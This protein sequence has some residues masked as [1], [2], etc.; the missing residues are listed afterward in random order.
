MRKIRILFFT[1][2]LLAN[3]PLHAQTDLRIWLGAGM[4]SLFV[5]DSLFS[6]IID[7]TV[8]LNSLGFRRSYCAATEIP[9][10]ESKVIHEGIIVSA[11]STEKSGHK[12]RAVI[13]NER[14]SC[15][16]LYE[17]NKDLTRIGRSAVLS[18]LN[19]L[20]KPADRNPQHDPYNAVDL[21]EVAGNIYNGRFDATFR[22]S[23]DNSY[24][25][26]HPDGWLL[27]SGEKLSVK[28]ITTLINKRGKLKHPDINHNIG[29]LLMK[30]DSIYAAID[31]YNTIPGLYLKA[32]LHE[33]EKLILSAFIFTSLD[34]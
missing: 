13:T 16:V 23:F 28:P 17:S 4:D 31:K 30:G 2:F 27:I 6:E 8:V 33:E 21:F 19:L 32:S 7:S 34:H 25:S 24:P 9:W 11:E 18:I 26:Y 20:S 29:Y 5:R 3:S 14:D 15:E 1:I 10:Q 22:Y 12:M